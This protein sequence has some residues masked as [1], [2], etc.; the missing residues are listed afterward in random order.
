MAEDLSAWVVLDSRILFKIIHVRGKF[1]NRAVSLKTSF[2]GPVPGSLCSVWYVDSSLDVFELQG[3]CFE[4]WQ[5]TGGAADV[6]VLP[7]F[8][9]FLLRIYLLLHFF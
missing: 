8:K 9:A 2:R 3:K 5:N 6:H 7:Q 1:E 4:D